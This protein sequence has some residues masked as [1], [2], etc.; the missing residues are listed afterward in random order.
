V[1]LAPI[2]STA[3]GSEPPES[4]YAMQTIN[5]PRREPL[6]PTIVSTHGLRL[7]LTPIA[8]AA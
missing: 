4:L 3:G 7:E 2:P 8:K 5:P 1:R 6:D